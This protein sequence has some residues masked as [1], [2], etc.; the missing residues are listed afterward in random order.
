MIS[1]TIV[2]A[3]LDAMR[4]DREPWTINAFAALAGEVVMADDPYRV[5]TYQWLAREQAYLA[6][7]LAYIKNHALHAAPLPVIMDE[8]LVNFD[9]Q[10][11]E[12]TAR[13][14]VELTGGGQGKAHQMLY[15]TCQPHMAELLRKGLAAE[16]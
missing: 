15:F 6:L 1:S 2:T 10:R 4:C 13:A 9:P 5:A 16:A 14:F 3:T 7:R 8:V 12:R 11:A